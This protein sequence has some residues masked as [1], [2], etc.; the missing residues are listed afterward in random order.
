MLEKAKRLA[1]SQSV[2]VV[3]HSLR[4]ADDLRARFSRM[5]PLNTAYRVRF[6]SAPPPRESYEYALWDHHAR[7]VRIAELEREIVRLREVDVGQ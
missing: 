3:C 1:E 7:D 5:E 4:M 6:A 2:V